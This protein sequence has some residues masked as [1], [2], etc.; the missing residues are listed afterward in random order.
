MAGRSLRAGLMFLGVIARYLRYW[1]LRRLMRPDR[2]AGLLEV[3]HRHCARR[4]H[5]GFVHLEGVYVKLGQVISMMTSFLPDAYLEELEGMQDAVPPR[6]FAAIRL[7]IEAE[8]GK[9]LAEV[10]ATFDPTAVASASLGQVHFATLAGSRPVAVKVQ[11]PGIEDIV[12]ADLAMIGLVLRIIGRF[13]PGLHPERIHADLSETVH[14]ELRYTVEGRNCERLAADFETDSHVEFPEVIW[15]HTTN[16]VLTMQ[17]MTGHKIT[18]VAA[19]RADGIEPR[20]VIKVLVES[21]FKQILLDGLYHADPHPGNFFVHRH[22][23]GK[24]VVTFLDFGAVVSLPEEIREGMRTVVYGY[25]SRNDTMVIDGMRTMGFASRGGNEAVFETAVRHYMDK[26]LH[27]DVADFSRIDLSQLD[28]FQNLDEMKLSFREIARAFEVPKNWFYVERTLG[29]LLGL[30]ARLD[31]TVDAFVYGFPYAVRFVFGD[32][33][34]LV[35][36][37]GTVST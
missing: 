10:Y 19:L 23:D 4:L 13:L 21:Y 14:N 31:P 24:P 11:Y 16:R 7:R 9:P 2:A 3:T 34:T 37:W 33:P 15:S 28:L 18:D 6:P 27:L 35:S 1:T 20:D 8:L 17:R 30:C 5:R 25:M 12:K 26:L 22:P 29:L 32:D 36:R